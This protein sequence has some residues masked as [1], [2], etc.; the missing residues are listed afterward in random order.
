VPYVVPVHPVLRIAL[1]GWWAEGWQRFIGRP[2]TLDDLIVPRQD[3]TQR[4]VNAS[5]EQ[6]YADL[7][8]LELPRRRQYENRAAFR[9]LCL[10]AGASEYHVRLIAHPK[11]TSAAKLY[12]RVEDHWEGMCAAVLCIDAGAWDGG[13][14]AVSPASWASPQR[15]VQVTLSGDFATAQSAQNDRTLVKPETKNPRKWTCLRGA[16]LVTRTG[17]EPMFSA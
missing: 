7:D 8:G 14:L 16:K 12:D 17:I 10:R 5:L 3:G 9:A 15:Q 2:P 11:P 13:P 1:E 4:R 6:F